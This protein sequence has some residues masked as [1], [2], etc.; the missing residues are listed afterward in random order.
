MRP[1]V[2]RALL[3]AITVGA[4]GC[5]VGDE[6]GGPPDA[7]ADASLPM[8]DA[9][10]LPSPDA[11]VLAG[12]APADAALDADDIDARSPDAA[13]DGSLFA[14]PCGGH[15]D[16]YNW[17]PQDVTARCCHGQPM[18]EADFTTAVDCGAC[19]I[20]CN[21]SNGES[22]QALGGRWFCRGCVASAD[23]W[24][25]CCSTSF[26]PYSC[27]ASDCAGN[28]SSMYCPASTHCVAGA[29][30]SSDYCAY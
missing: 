3:A 4:T 28:C 13:A 18:H 16:G 22:C 1:R 2:A 23:C 9:F 29:P 17:Y 25:K 27:A 15:P 14:N 20:A 6:L 19:G 8:P 26:T 10:M 5:S 30:D 12:D 7:S 24:S 11:I 21:A